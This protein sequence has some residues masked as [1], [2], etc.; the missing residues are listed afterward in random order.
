MRVG[1]PESNRMK[2]TRSENHQRKPR[3]HDQQRQYECAEVVL[4]EPTGAE[5]L[6]VVQVG[7]TR[8]QAL[9]KERH[10]FKPGDRIWLKPDLSAV[11]VFDVASGQRL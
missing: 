10:R 5:T 1:D 9:F 3:D 8:V 7:T 6:I 2:Q 11:H 4:V